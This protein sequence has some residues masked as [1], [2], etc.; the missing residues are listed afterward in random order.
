[1]LMKFHSQTVNTGLR[2]GGTDRQR[3][4]LRP[5]IEIQLTFPC[6][7]DSS[8]PGV[9]VAVPLLQKDQEMLSS[10]MWR[11]LMP[12]SAAAVVVAVVVVAVVVVAV[13][14]VVLVAQH[15]LVLGHWVLPLPE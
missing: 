12:V 5:R 13:A 10:Q 11:G 7:H 14:V 3:Q 8:F 9:V 2:K 15:A 1:M 6:H 4:R